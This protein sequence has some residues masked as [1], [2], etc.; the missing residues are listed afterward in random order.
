MSDP[1][2][3]SGV[4]AMRDQAE[5]CAA[6][7]SPMY[8]ALAERMADDLAAGG[9]VSEV[10]GPWAAAPA[11]AAVTLRLLGGVHRLVLQRRA[12]EL[13]I[14]YPGV[15]GRFDPG[16]SGDLD[17]LW[18]AFTAV[19]S[20]HGSELS[21]GLDQ[22]PQTNEVGRSAALAGALRYLVAEA[23]VGSGVAEAAGHAAPALPVA[24]A[25]IGASAGL[26]LRPDRIR[27]TSADGTDE[28]GPASAPVV[29]AGGW[30][31][32][33]P[34]VGH[35]SARIVARAGCDR[36]PLDPLSAADRL[37]LTSY[38]WPDQTNRLARLR[39]AFA[40]AAAEP[41]PIVRADAADWVR[42]LSPRLG[43]WTV[44]WHSVMWQYLSPHDAAATRA[45]VNALGERASKTAPVAEVALEPLALDQGARDR[46][47]AGTT[48][49][50]FAVTVTIWTGGELR[51]VDLGRAPGHGIPVRW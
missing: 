47:S 29:M 17:H 6:M 5:A 30:D 4:A 36:S 41:V 51:R 16:E 26:N 18:Q 31:T 8:A 13:A 45:A 43:R 25:E 28:M 24:L 19:C 42:E 21:A 15:G 37:T 23:A 1:R 38:T 3:G 10:L 33:A 34:G 32:P 39:G 22:P 7:G 2:P 46:G 40:M 14:W 12:A 9:V 20:A 49:P 35:P 11:S 50:H 27:I 48:D 44:L